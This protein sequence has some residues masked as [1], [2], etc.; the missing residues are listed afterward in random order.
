M[1]ETGTC[2]LQVGPG[3]QGVELLPVEGLNGQS[4]PVL[5]KELLLACS[6][7]HTEEPSAP[8]VP[9]CVLGEAR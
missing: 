9:V 6:C 7:S 5:E 4:E 2:G 8:E 1:K 3:C